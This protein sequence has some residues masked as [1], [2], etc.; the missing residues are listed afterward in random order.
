MT[1]EEIYTI[2]RFMTMTASFSLTSLGASPFRCDVYRTPFG[3]LYLCHT[4]HLRTGFRLY[5]GFRAVIPDAP[6][7]SMGGMC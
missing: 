1:T 3:A 6:Q 4:T 5:F 7:A 2:I